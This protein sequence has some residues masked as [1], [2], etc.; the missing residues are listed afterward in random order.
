MTT[1]NEHVL[2]LASGRP[3]LIGIGSVDVQ[4]LAT[5]AVVAEVQRIKAIR[6][7]G[8][9]L[10]PGFGA[11]PLHFD[12]PLLEPAYE[13]AQALRLP[14]FPMS[15]P[16]TPDL[17]INDPA[18]I[19]RVAWRWPDPQIIV[20]HGAW[21]RVAEIVGVAFRYANVHLAP[22]MYL[23]LAGSQPYVEA[24]TSFL[25]DQFLFGSSFPFRPMRQSV[26]VFVA[27]PWRSGVLEAVP[28]D[29][30]ARLLLR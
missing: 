11:T 25:R 18:A 7:K 15:G 10:E 19:G 2:E 12:D 24:A 1:S 29:K 20:S 26:D 9:N 8:L 21:P 30:A 3:E 17:A 4:R 6:L 28:H 27:L 23:F 13:A 16:T 22:D 5:D 14:V